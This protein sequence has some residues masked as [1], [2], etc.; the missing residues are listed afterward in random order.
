M[1]K[2]KILSNIDITIEAIPEHE[3][4][5]DCFDDEQHIKDVCELYSWT[6]WGWCTVKVTAKWNG[7]EESVYIGACSYESEDDFIK[8]SGYFEDMKKEA[9]D[10]LFA[11]LNK[12]ESDMY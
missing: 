6:V 4:P 3:H 7:I 1:N 9:I 10:C 2:K 8:N 5:R 11:E 12:I